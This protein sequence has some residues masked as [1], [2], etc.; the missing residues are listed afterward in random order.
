MVFWFF[1]VKVYRYTGR[2]PILGAIAQLVERFHG[3]EEVRGSIPLSS[4]NYD[5]R[6]MQKEYISEELHCLNCL[7]LNQSNFHDGKM[8]VNDYFE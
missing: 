6:S 2:V 3:M 5:L 7:A 4:T 1:D 8:I